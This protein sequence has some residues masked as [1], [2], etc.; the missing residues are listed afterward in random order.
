MK[1]RECEGEL[2][3]SSCQRKGNQQ[4]CQPRGVRH[5][6]FVLI[7]CPD[8]PAPTSPFVWEK[9][10]LLRSPEDAHRPHPRTA[11]PVVIHMQ[12]CPGA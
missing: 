7:L 5:T 12:F 11:I 6:G 9:F 8:A 2:Q 1:S 10:L 4:I 3:T